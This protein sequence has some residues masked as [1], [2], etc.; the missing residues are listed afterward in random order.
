[1]SLTDLL[2]RI[3]SLFVSSTA[4]ILYSIIMYAVVIAMIFIMPKFLHIYLQIFFWIHLFFSSII[5]FV[6]FKLLLYGRKLCYKMLRN[7]VVIILVVA[8]MVWSCA[9]ANNL[10]VDSIHYDNFRIFVMPALLVNVIFVLFFYLNFKLMWQ[11]ES[12]KLRCAISFTLAYTVGFYLCFCAPLIIENDGTLETLSQ[13]KFD[14]DSF[15]STCVCVV[16]TYLVFIILSLEITCYDAIQPSKL[17][18]LFKRK[19]AMPQP[20]GFVLNLGSEQV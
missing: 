1:M 19:K 17:F 11:V 15:I 4:E 13:T 3:A 12:F 6:N 14:I 20:N 18:E 7:L 10:S 8:L 5:T 9:K 16:Y 2:Y